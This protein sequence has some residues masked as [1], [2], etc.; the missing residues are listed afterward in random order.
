MDEIVMNDI[1]SRIK[2]IGILLRRLG[3]TWLIIKEFPIR[4]AFW[5]K[6]FLL[7]RTKHPGESIKLQEAIH[8]AEQ[9]IEH[10]QT[11]FWYSLKAISLIDEQT[12]DYKAE[13]LSVAWSVYESRRIHSLISD[14]FRAQNMSRTQKHSRKF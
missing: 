6:V 9:L 3:I 5:E 14:F 7:F 8:R 10:Y 1:L 12:H 13:K 2:N 11:G 4:R